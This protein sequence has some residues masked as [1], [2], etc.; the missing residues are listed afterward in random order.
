ML[1]KHPLLVQACLI[2]FCTSTTFTSFWTTLTFLLSS[3]PYS[4]PPLYI[5]LFGLIGIGALSL[6]P[7]YSRLVIDRFP[8]L[9]SVII[10]QVFCLTGI[11]IGTFIGTFT[12]AGP[13]IQAFLIDLGLLTSQI[14]NRAAIFSLEPTARNRVN[15]AFMVAVF[16]GQLVGT[17]AGNALY[18]QG[19]W[20]WSGGVSA[21]FIGLALVLCGIRGPWEGEWWGWS[22]GWGMERKGENHHGG[23]ELEEE[24]R[25]MKKEKMLGR[26][27]DGGSKD[28]VKHGLGD[29]HV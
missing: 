17:A 19:G 14:A 1:F 7:F 5:G 25:E 8:S 15:T 28:S 6:G 4:Y 11:L 2:G 22:G 13:V 29:D 24:R 3:P 12:I 27:G 23:G 18:A 20:R 26:E 10:G 16:I 21:G 9:H